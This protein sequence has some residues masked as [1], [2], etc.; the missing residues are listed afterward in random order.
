MKASVVRTAGWPVPEWLN[1]DLPP[2]S[3]SRASC[4]CSLCWPSCPS[5]KR[6]IEAEG[7]EGQRSL[8]P[9]RP[10][11][12]IGRLALTNLVNGVGVGFCAPSIA[13]WFYQRYG[14]GSATIGLLFAA[15]SLGATVPYTLGPS[16]A[17]KIG[18]VNAVVSIRLVGVATLAILPLMPSFP[19]AAAV[20]F[21][22]MTRQRASIPLRQS[23]SMEV[24]AEEERSAAAGLSN[25]PSQLSA[26][27]SPAIA[28]YLFQSVSLE[29]PF[30]IGTALQ[31]LHAILYF[32]LFRN[33]HPPEEEARVEPARTMHPERLDAS[34]Q[35]DY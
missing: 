14:A 23:Y 13:C 4:R 7:K 24:V 32:S 34:R 27:V 31:L 18:L 17:R 3:C 22:R 5:T 28:G 12:I 26:A 29:L 25:L 8:L 10:R 19:L 2:S 16:L 35:A 1:Q 30:E 21:V 9:R 20:H 15:V 33:I 11:G 6:R